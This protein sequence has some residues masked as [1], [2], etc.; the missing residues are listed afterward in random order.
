[1][2][3]FLFTNDPVK[4]FSCLTLYLTMYQKY[5]RSSHLPG[6]SRLFFS[7][8]FHAEYP[9]GKKTTRRYAATTERKRIN[10]KASL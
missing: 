10:S 2:G 5:L 4:M 9:Y 1:M 3:F 7:S 6:E 8:L